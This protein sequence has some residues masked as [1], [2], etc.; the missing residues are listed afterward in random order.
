MSRQQGRSYL[1]SAGLKRGMNGRETSFLYRE[2][3]EARCYTSDELR[4][5]VCPTIV[6]VGANIGMFAA[7][8]RSEWPDSRIWCYE[9][10]PEVAVLL[11]A[12]FEDHPDVTIIEAAVEAASGSVTMTFFPK[13]SIL[14]TIGGDE[15]RIRNNIAHNADQWTRVEGNG[16]RR[17]DAQKVAD[18]LVTPERVE[19]NAIGIADVI[20][21]HERVD[22]LKIDVEGHEGTIIGALQPDMAERVSAIALEPDLTEES[23]VAISER[24]VSLGYRIAAGR[25]CARPGR[26]DLDRFIAIRLEA[27]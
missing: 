26:V 12:N 4:L 3:F 25:E 8:A 15:K 14:S 1:A 23:I 22:L 16:E 2:I 5:P 21:Q 17:L 13:N 18:K 7:F 6:D 24:L 27:S 19:V 11:R 20:G 9:P 10:V